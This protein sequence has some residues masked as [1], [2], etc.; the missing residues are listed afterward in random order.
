MGIEW[1]VR[2]GELWT[3]PNLVTLSRLPLLVGIVVLVDSVWR[4]P[5]F[6]LVVVSDGI[7][8]WLARRLDQKTELGAMLDPALDKLTALVLVAALFPR[9]GLDWAYLALFFSRDL[10]V[11]SLAPLVPL[12]GFDTSK[13][14]ARLFGKVVTNVQFFTIVAMLV[15]HARAT[16]ALIWGLAVA[17]ALAIADYVVFV[18]RELS[19]GDYLESRGETVATYVGVFAVFAAVSWLLLGAEL[20]AFVA[21]FL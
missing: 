10:F 20:R 6:A 19:D 5:L 4:Y 12:Y 14:Q 3:V 16:E 1:R 2:A 17:S 15:P 21:S 8:G 18:V 13:V 9:T 11:V 7:D